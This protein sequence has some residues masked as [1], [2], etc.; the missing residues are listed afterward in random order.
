MDKEAFSRLQKLE[1]IIKQDEEYMSRREGYLSDRKQFFDL[2]HALPDNTEGFLLDY[3][4]NIADMVYRK[5]IIA[6]ENMR[7][8]DEQK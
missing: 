3:I 8:P 2:I 5:L 1:Q 6:C 4:N 7:F